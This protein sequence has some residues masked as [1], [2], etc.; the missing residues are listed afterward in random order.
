MKKTL[1]ILISLLVVAIATWYLLA[2]ILTSHDCTSSKDYCSNK[3]DGASCSYGIWCDEFGRICG[4]T[5]CVGL[6]LGECWDGEC[7]DI[8]DSSVGEEEGENKTKVDRTNLKV[9]DRLAK[10]ME[11]AKE[12]EKIYI[13]IFAPGSVGVDVA[14]ADLVNAGVK[15]ERAH[16]MN[17]GKIMLTGYTTKSKMEAISK[18]NWVSKIELNSEMTIF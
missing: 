3:K 7:V 13:M 10:A 18:I 8:K 5:S 1:I 14:K 4:G 9:T 17:N 2:F 6:G 16:V 11:A 12:N 15:D